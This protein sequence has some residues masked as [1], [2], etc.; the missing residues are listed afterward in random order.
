VFGSVDQALRQASSIAFVMHPYPV[1]FRILPQEFGWQSI[2]QPLPVQPGTLGGHSHVK[3]S[4]S[5]WYHKAPI[6]V[7]SRNIRRTII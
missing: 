4:F 7:L 3:Q 6:I 2:S 1:W 5:P